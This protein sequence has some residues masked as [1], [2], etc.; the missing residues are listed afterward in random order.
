MSSR[1]FTSPRGK[2][3]TGLAKKYPLDRG[4]SGT[5]S[6]RASRVA[7]RSGHI[8]V[9][10]ASSDAAAT[11]TATLARAGYRLAT[12]VD[13]DEALHVMTRERFDL[14]IIGGGD[15]ACDPITKGLRRIRG[16]QGPARTA[17]NPAA[18]GILVLMERA[19]PKVDVRRR[20]AL[21]A[22][23]DDVLVEPAP[24]A[25]LLLRIATLLRRIA[26]APAEPRET[27]TL[28]D[29]HIDVAAHEVLIGE[30]LVDFTAA[31]FMVLRTLAER[32]G[33][34]CTRASLATSDRGRT[35]ARGVDMRISRIR[36]KL[37]GAGLVIESVRGE[38]YRLSRAR[39]GAS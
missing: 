34:L 37:G 8:L 5:A 2:K 9:A 13:I 14:L 16:H 30:R 27:L 15:H 23:A 18:V 17:T 39:A 35:S 24:A 38:G 21:A 10:V 1:R 7:S 36:R 22:G 28:A 19:A 33:R 6:A 3:L 11:T 31:E 4:G 25:E 12:V 32:Q 20:A 26:R 29:L